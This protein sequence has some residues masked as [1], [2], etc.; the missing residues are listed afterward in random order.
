[1]ALKKGSYL[2]VLYDLL[3]K[4]LAWTREIQDELFKLLEAMAQEFERIGAR[5]GDALKESDPRETTEW[6]SD[7]ERLLGLPDACSRTGL[8][9]TLEVRRNE[10]LARYTAS[11][12]ITAQYYIDIAAQ[13]GFAIQIIEYRPFEV[14]RSTVGQALTNGNWI[15]AFAVKG[16]IFTFIQF[17][18][19]LSV[20]GE[21]LRIWGNEPLECAINRIKPAHNVVLFIYEN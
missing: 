5:A 13:L 16:P 20:V 2:Q 3:P 19:G 10:I 12:S 18:T 8:D 17:R 15:F 4:G 14:G 9:R 6:I 1:M 7:W 11:G 21:P